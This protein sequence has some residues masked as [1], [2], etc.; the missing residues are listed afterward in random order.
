M[1]GAWLCARCMVANLFSYHG[2]RRRWGQAR[3]ITYP[4]ACCWPHEL[5]M[6]FRSSIGTVTIYVLLGEPRWDVC[7]CARPEACWMG[8]CTSLLSMLAQN[9]RRTLSVLAPQYG[10]EAA[11]TERSWWAGG[12][13]RGPAWRIKGCWMLGQFRMQASTRDSFESTINSYLYAV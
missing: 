8:M 13:G 6:C 2:T 7:T 4:V 5:I 9:S 1:Q 10:K 3:V 12:V 11:A